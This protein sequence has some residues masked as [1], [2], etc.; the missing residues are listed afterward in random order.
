M[1]VLAAAAAAGGPAFADCLPGA[2]GAV[3]TCTGV[4]ANGLVV[5]GGRVDIA[6]GATL[7]AGTAPAALTASTPAFGEGRATLNVNGAVDGGAATGVLLTTGATGSSSWPPSNLVD[8]TVGETGVIRGRTGLE[9][10]AS[11]SGSGPVRANITNSGS[12]TSSTGAAIVGADT[13]RTGI[14][15]LENRAGGFIGGVDAAVQSLIN[16]GTIDGG[17]GSAYRFSPSSGVWAALP[18]RFDNS[19]VFRSSGAAATIDLGVTVYGGLVNSGQIINTGA[20]AAING[21]IGQIENKESGRIESAGPVAINATDGLTLINR[22]LIVGSVVSSSPSP[23]GVYLDLAGGLVQGDVRLG[24]GNDSVIASVDSATLS[25]SSVSGVLD[26]GGGTNTLQLA[27]SS[28]IDLD[29]LLSNAGLAQNFQSHGLVLSKGAVATISGSSSEFLTV[30]GIGGLVIDGDV[31]TAG[32]AFYGTALYESQLDFTNNG[33][34][35]TTFTGPDARGQT[36]AIVLG[37]LASFTNTG[38]IVST[39]GDGVS[40]IMGN[41]FGSLGG[42]RF[43]NSGSIIATNT[44]LE[45]TRGAFDNSGLIRS[46]DGVGL[47]SGGSGLP[48]V[49]ASTNSG[50]IEG[51]TAGLALSDILFVNEGEIASSHGVGVDPGSFSIIDNRAGGVISG[52]TA[53]IG[54]R[55]SGDNTVIR[56]AGTLNG[57]VV[58]VSNGYW[59]DAATSIFIDDGGVVNGSIRLGGGR[60]TYITDL[61][62]L[63]DGRFT[64]V[65]GSVVADDGDDTLVLRVRAD[66]AAILAPVAGFETL[67]YELDNDATLTLTAAAPLNTTLALGGE[68]RV[69]LTADLGN[70]TTNQP[71]I[72]I[73]YSRADAYVDPLGGSLPP[74][75]VSVVSRGALTVDQTLSYYNVEGVQLAGESTFENAG[76]MTVNGLS[77]ASTAPVGV[78]GGVARQGEAINSGTIALNYA[79]G[80]SDL[81][82][83]VNTGELIQLA[84]G[85]RSVGVSQTAVIENSGTIRTAGPAVQASGLA[86]MS[87]VNGGLIASTGATAIQADSGTVFSLVNTGEI[88]GQEAAIRTSQGGDRIRNEGMITGAIDLGAGDDVIENY[89]AIVGAV[90]L[91]AGN[92]TFVQWVGGLMNGAVDGGAGLDTLTI[93]STGG[94]SIDGAQ[95]VNFERFTQI[96]GGVLNYSGAFQTATIGLDGVFASVGAGAALSTTGTFTFTGGADAEHLTNAGAIAGGVSLGGGADTVVNLGSIAGDVLLGDGDDSFTEGAGST[97]GGTVDGGAGTDTYIVALSGDRA[98]LNAR[99]GFERLAATGT[100]T[101]NLTLDQSWETIDLAASGLNLRLA[102]FTVGALNGGDGAQTVVVDGQVASI[103]LGGGA[104]S[105]TIN[106]AF[107]GAVDLGSGDDVLRLTGAAFTGTAN[108][109]L[110]ADRLEFTVAGTDAA[111]TALNL[112]PFSGFETLRLISGTSSVSGSHAFDR[113]EVSG[114]R[115]IGAAGSTLTAPTITVAQG[116]TFGSAGTVVGDI[117]VSGVLSPGA[118]PGTMTVTGNVALAAGSTTLFEIDPTAVDKLVISGRLSIAQGATLK[119]AGSAVLAPGRTLDLIV[120]A[121]GVSGSFSTVQ[122]GQADGFY[123]RSTATRVQALGLFTTSPSFSAQA[124]QVITTFNDALVADRL[125]APLAAALPALTDQ[126]TYRSDPVALLRVTP[127]AYASAVRLATDDGLS[128]A[129]AARGQAR[130][131]PDAPGL[132]GFGQAIAGRRK[133]DG[134]AAAGVADGKIDSSGGLAGVGYGVKSA[135]IGAFVGYLDGRQ[136]IA[137]LDA[138]TQSDGFVVG[139]QGGLRLGDFQI[140]ATAARN[141]ADL[142]TRRTA[143][144]AGTTARGG[145]QLESW[146]ADVELSYQARLND[147]WTL[148][149]RLGASYVAVTRDALVEQGGGAFGLAVAGDTSTDWFVD[150]RLELIGGQA[151]GERLHPYAAVGFRSRVGGDEARASGTLVGLATPSSVTGLDQD[152]TLATLG[153]GAA[154]DLSRGLTVFGGYDGAFGDNG[155]QAAS[156][157]LRWAF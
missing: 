139:A 2:G 132:F 137:G 147:G 110:G 94:G 36:Y 49:I 52:A 78:S 22:G 136:R 91:G 30:A 6:A 51:K 121:G 156:L 38:S 112:A 72:Y 105:L 146:I 134:D 154:Y 80:V 65:T 109:G 142:E 67:G 120:A 25:L 152:G 141:K 15:V 42:V 23:F 37:T 83:F 144:A 55:A 123:L 74:P 44:A 12:I 138:R 127:Q 145:Y 107:G 33:A 31:T 124:S 10:N 8:I 92:D 114:G 66:A 50:T 150:G 89:G 155:R 47:T 148:R 153:L 104:D 63:V 5:T 95:F 64:N 131:A 106:G 97:V 24:A 135:W 128:I 58:L 19:G 43:H 60:D 26:G 40:A 98:G 56:N 87:V 85:G 68:G 62:R 18:A 59:G 54:Y 28:D 34:I 81:E 82:R 14:L 45:V 157:G 13:S 27:V 73:S 151:A 149:P 41:P 32:Q 102:G 118:S 116:A 75:R 90:Q 143:G 93:D 100:G 16:A 88:T 115:L 77:N 101:L 140:G 4:T 130:F 76:V 29:G 86:G 11:L 117:A 61:S 7:D 126:A 99:A 9:L 113:I 53:S 39:G 133:L 122:G 71:L 84:G 46:T 35:T 20:G 103:G 79:T 108:G 96:G 125:G 69:D 119:L 129:E 111:P 70:G 17:T 21:K 1:L 48:R 3:V 57:D